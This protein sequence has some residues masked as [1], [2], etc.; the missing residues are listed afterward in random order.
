LYTKVREDI[1]VLYFLVGNTIIGWVYVW[2][3]IT[4]YES[5]ILFERDA[6][7]SIKTEDEIDLGSLYPRLYISGV[8][9]IPGFINFADAF[10]NI[11]FLVGRDHKIKLISIVQPLKIIDSLSE[12][13]GLL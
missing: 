6:K 2:F 9:K 7:E 1:K 10:F 12:E 11:L 5:K 8:R 13:K 3:R 4:E